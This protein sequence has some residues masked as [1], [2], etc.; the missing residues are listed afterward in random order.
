MLN[1]ISKY[2]RVERTMLPQKTVGQESPVNLNTSRRCG[3][4]TLGVW[5]NPDESSAANLLDQFCDR[6]RAASHV[7]HSCPAIN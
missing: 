3:G 6:A 5:L 4:R 7:K 1:D 2:N